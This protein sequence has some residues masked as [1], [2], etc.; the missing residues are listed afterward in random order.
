MN[1]IGLEFRIITVAGNFGDGI[2]GF[3]VIHHTK[4]K[5]GIDSGFAGFRVFYKIQYQGQGALDVAMRQL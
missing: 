3:R 2:V 4:Y 1:G 5:Q